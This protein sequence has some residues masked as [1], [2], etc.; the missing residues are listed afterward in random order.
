MRI[1]ECERREQLLDWTEAE[2][3]K[4]VILVRA[5]VDVENVV[6]GV[7]RL[8]RH[9]RRTLVP[10]VHP[11]AVGVEAIRLLGH[12]V[13]AQG[14]VG[15]VQDENAAVEVLLVL[16]WAV[17]VLLVEDQVEALNLPEEN[18]N[19]VGRS[20]HA[21]RSASARVGSGGD[22]VALAAPGAGVL[23]ARRERGCWSVMAAAQASQ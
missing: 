11:A 13:D 6:D 18:V 5:P 15:G 2:L 21:E 9:E 12:G 17:E 23:C 4:E 10:H 1:V 8:G 20:V 7:P 3:H 22:V 19:A 14:L 16:L